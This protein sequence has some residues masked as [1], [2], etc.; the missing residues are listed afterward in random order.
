MAAYL[1]LGVFVWLLGLCVGSFLNVV[2]YR[3]P[4]DLSLTQPAR[5]FCPQCK[6]PIAWHDNI[7]VLS[8]IL[9]RARCRHCH[10]PISSQYP[11]VEG[12]TGLTFIIVYHLLVS[13]GA[14]AGYAFTLWP[15]PIDAPVL[16][17]WLVL[18]AA[19]VACAAMDIV[20][21]MV[22][23]RVTTAASLAGIVLFAVWPR[24]EIT[25]AAAASPLAAGAAA[26]LLVGAGMAWW[27]M[28]AMDFGVPEE[29]HQ[30]SHA[31]NAIA[32]YSNT[33]PP[34]ALVAGS[35]QSAA[36]AP[37]RTEADDQLEQRRPDR[38]WGAAATLLLVLLSAALL[39][40]PLTRGESW[41]TLRTW[42]LPAVVG[43]L[44]ILTVVIG[45][46]R[47]PA[48]EEVQHAIESEQPQARRTALRE[49]A[50]LSP[51]L[52]A[53]AG[54]L[55]ILAFWA[56]AGAAW[57]RIV[58]WSPDGHFAPLAGITYALLGAAAGAIAGWVLR[59]VF[60]LIF[61]REAF[62]VGDIHILAAAGAAGGW[63]IALLGLLMAIGLA[64][65]GL[66]LG[67]IFKNAV[68]IPFGPWLGLGF[69]LAL[70]LNEAAAEIANTQLD[71][72][73]YAWQTRPEI[74]LAAA[75]IMLVGSGAAILLARLF[76]KAVE[77]MTLEA[78]PE[79]V[80]S[81]ASEIPGDDHDNTTNP[82]TSDGADPGQ[83]E[84]PQDAGR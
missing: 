22:D 60:T 7:P 13:D 41:Q 32:M 53:G 75:G 21:Y 42:D 52:I 49:L 10:E 63:D 27:A 71:A 57:G 55:L 64:V 68:I 19:L 61:G 62:G 50:W 37:E 20:T 33:E 47:R 23:V 31:N 8:W 1:I 70:W 12:L 9:L 29:E 54:V 69:L 74:L 26:S 36:S 76:R 43:L 51:A 28:R 44:V 5:S 2:V 81:G 17:A 25:V 40:L 30:D 45:G 66:L 46:R 18:T 78:S 77:R 73:Q 83:P 48:D 59:I 4:L 80:P 84:S 15:T 16:L 72:L 6:T 14:R 35:K 58:A 3:L 79:I 65:I 67:L 11:L 82:K 24:P 39:L 56:P 38:G 34:D